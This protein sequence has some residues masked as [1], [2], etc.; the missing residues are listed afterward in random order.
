[1][2]ILLV[3]CRCQCLHFVTLNKM[4]GVIKTFDLQTYPASHDAV[5]HSINWLPYKLAVSRVPENWN[6]A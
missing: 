1:M 5:P 3:C 6:L 4:N 2:I